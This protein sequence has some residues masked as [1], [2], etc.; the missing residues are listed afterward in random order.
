M[1]QNELSAIREVNT[2]CFEK[3]SMEINITASCQNQEGY[4]N[5]G[6]CEL[7]SGRSM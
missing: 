4:V 5:K 2:K 6:A 7:N 1:R 3:S